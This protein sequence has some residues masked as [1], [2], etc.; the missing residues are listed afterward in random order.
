M[1]FESGVVAEDWRSAMIVPLYKDKGERTEY[2]NFR[3]INLL[4]VVGKM[5]LGILVDRVRKVT[6]GCVDQIYTLKQIGEKA[7]EKKCSLYVGF[8]DLKRA[9]DR[10]SREALWQVLRM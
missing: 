10:V 3:G 8:I 7:W 9:Y 4:I 6:E 1:A 2:S 5:Y